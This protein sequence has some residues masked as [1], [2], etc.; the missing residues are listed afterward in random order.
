MGTLLISALSDRQ[1]GSMILQL[2][3]VVNWTS[4]IV[5]GWQIVQLNVRSVLELLADPGVHV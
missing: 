2:L 3:Q 1:P 4:S 5:A